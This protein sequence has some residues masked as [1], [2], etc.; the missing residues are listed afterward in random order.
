MNRWSTEEKTTVGC[1]GAAFVIWLI[2]ATLIVTL[3]VA[4]IRYLWGA[5]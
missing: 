1:M 4:A 2:W 5:A 3:V